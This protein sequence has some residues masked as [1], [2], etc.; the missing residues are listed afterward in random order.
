[1]RAIQ[2][3]ALGLALASAPAGAEES[4]KPLV[5]FTAPRASAQLDL[6]QRYDQLLNADNLRTWMQRMTVRPH[7]LGSPQ[8]KA[9][10]EF[11]A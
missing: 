10:A 3:V 7:H 1:M 4:T 6:E 2:F 5:G 8:A 9:N 11:I